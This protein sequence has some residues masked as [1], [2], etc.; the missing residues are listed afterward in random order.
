MD[1]VQDD[2][3]FTRIFVNYELQRVSRILYRLTSH[4]EFSNCYKLVIYL[5]TVLQHC[6]SNHSLYRYLSS[7]LSFSSSS[8]SLF[9]FSVFRKL[10]VPGYFPAYCSRI[11]FL[12][13][14]FVHLHKLFYFDGFSQPTRSFSWVSRLTYDILLFSYLFLSKHRWE[15]SWSGLSWCVAFKGLCGIF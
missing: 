9:F 2:L 6:K 5:G 7:I 15:T 11:V 8:P 10:M 14:S 3:K 4:L 12:Y 1:T 13:L